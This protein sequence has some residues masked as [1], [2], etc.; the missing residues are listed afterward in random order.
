MKFLA[1]MPN[2]E[3][4]RRKRNRF[5]RMVHVR[6]NALQ[7]AL[8]DPPKGINLTKLS[9]FDDGGIDE[10]SIVIV[11][12]NDVLPNDLEKRD[13][14]DINEFI[15][16]NLTV[17]NDTPKGAKWSNNQKIETSINSEAVQKHAFNERTVKVLDEKL[18]KM[19]NA[20]IEHRNVVLKS[21]P[22]NSEDVEQKI[23]TEIKIVEI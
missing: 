19:Q 1:E 22:F 2:S 8:L 5:F 16:K 20:E 3:D 7:I 10:G 23:E 6:E 21:K 15:A 9:K 13:M 4:P 11:S 12:A 14:D 17:I 18:I